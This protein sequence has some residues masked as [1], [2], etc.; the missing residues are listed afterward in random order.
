M[1]D[2]IMTERIIAKADFNEIRRNQDTLL[3]GGKIQSEEETTITKPTGGVYSIELTNSN[4]VIDLKNPSKNLLINKK[5][6]DI[7]RFLKDPSTQ[8]L[9]F[10]IMKS[11]FG[12]KYIA[13][14]GA[15]G[16]I[17]RQVKVYDG[18]V[19]LGNY[20][21]I[22]SFLGS[23]LAKNNIIDNK[24]IFDLYVFNRKL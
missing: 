6:L 4:S 23:D 16:T 10:S 5:N 14:V 1:N 22:R 18:K 11:M 13:I 9:K 7:V 8:S 2:R 19:L 3:K 12:N 15:I 17:N 21:C 20:R 24:N